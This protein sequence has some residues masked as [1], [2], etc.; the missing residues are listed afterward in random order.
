MK[1]LNGIL[2]SF[3]NAEIKLEQSVQVSE[4]PES[5]NLQSDPYLIL[6]FWCLVCMS[7]IT[8]LNVSYITILKC[9]KHLITQR[10]SLTKKFQSNS[11][12]ELNSCTSDQI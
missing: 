9:L 12:V 8:F 6:I 3:T 11:E 5:K 2:K 1:E 7:C 4:S 10:I